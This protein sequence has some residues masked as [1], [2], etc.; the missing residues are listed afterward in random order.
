MQAVLPLVVALAKPAIRP[1]H[2]EEIIELTATQIPYAADTFKLS[3]LLDAPL[4]D[5]AEDVEFIGDSAGKQLKLEH[6]LREE[7]GAFWGQEELTIVPWKGVDAPCAIG[8]NIVEINERLDDHLM[9][10]N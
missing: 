7:I 10:L 3:D 5:V 8:G 1:R 4:L 2:W 9:K 6:E